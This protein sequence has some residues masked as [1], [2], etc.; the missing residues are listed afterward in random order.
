M[1]Q[2]FFLQRLPLRTAFPRPSRRRNDLCT[3][4]RSSPCIDNARP[5]QGSSLL[6]KEKRKT[7]KKLQTPWH[8][9]VVFFK[10][11][12]SHEAR[13]TSK[14]PS[15]AVHVCVSLHSPLHSPPPPQPLP[16]PPPLCLSTCLSLAALIIPLCFY[17]TKAWTHKH[18]YIPTHTNICNIDTY[19]CH[20]SHATFAVCPGAFL[21]NIRRWR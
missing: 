16:L 15:V 14:A 13:V 10:G 19:G 1:N 12:M 5:R 11:N 20:A 6:S 17:Y 9:R 2:F 8:R 7:H 4:A 18:T 21:E 3:H